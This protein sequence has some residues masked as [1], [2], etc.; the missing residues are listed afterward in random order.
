MKTIPQS[1][2][3]F[4]TQLLLVKLHLYFPAV[5]SAHMSTMLYI[6]NALW[7]NR[8]WHVDNVAESTTHTYLASESMRKVSLTFLQNP[9]LHQLLRIRS[10]LQRLIQVV[11]THM[12]LKLFLVGLNRRSSSRVWQDVAL[13]QLVL[14]WPL[15]KTLMI[16]PH[17]LQHPLP[18]SALCT[19][20]CHCL[21]CLPS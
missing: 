5:G 19:G 21:Q 4:E 6:H 16:P 20:N 7:R 17:Q 3:P 2:V 12:L 18:R 13:N 10:T 15:R 1:N 8:S 14:L 11:R 9:L